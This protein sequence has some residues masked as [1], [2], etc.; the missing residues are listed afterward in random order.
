MRLAFIAL[1]LCLAGAYTYAAFT[2][3]HFLSS[4]GR[5]GPG[6][7]PR[8]I[9]VGLVL[10]CLA[11]LAFEWRRRSEAPPP[12][13]H[14]RTTIMVGALSAAFVLSLTILGGYLAMVAF[15]L[16]TL[17]VLNRKG[18]VQNVAIALVLPTAIY[19]M[20]EYWLNVATPESRILSQWIG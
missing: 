17:T 5:L 18:P 11:E 8:F 9:G 10:A 20:F 3:L 1:I 13:E 4:T 14:A 12:S 7:F 15:L 19:V 6:F 2:D 16:V